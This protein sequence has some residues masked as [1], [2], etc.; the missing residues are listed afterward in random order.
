MVEP[1]DPI[2]RIER[3]GRLLDE[4]KISR[5]EYEALK[6]S[7]ILTPDSAELASAFNHTTPPQTARS[8]RWWTERIL[9][10]L[11]GV[12]LAKNVYMAANAVDG[13]IPLS[14]L[15][16]L[17]WAGLAGVGLYTWQP[18]KGLLRA[19]VGRKILFGLSALFVGL[20]AAFALGWV[21]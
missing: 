13:L 16:P 7:V 17:I 1:I 2:D 12:G 8:G 19:S 20:M 10:A 5:N 14:L 4:G 18:G 11:G 3:L 21:G 6:S 15:D 9:L